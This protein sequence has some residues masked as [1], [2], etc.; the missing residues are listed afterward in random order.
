MTMPNTS[1]REGKRVLVVDDEPRMIGFIRMNLELEGHLVI[2]AHNGLEALDAVRTQLPDLVLLDLMMPEIDGLEVCRRLKA[3]PVTQRTIYAEAGG[4]PGHR[5]A[6]T[7]PTVNASS[8]SFFA[9]TLAALDAAYLRP[10][11]DGVL[12]FQE[13]GGDLIH[14]WLREGGDVGA[15]LDDLDERYRASLPEADRSEV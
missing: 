15:V 14:A 9:D 4:Q 11:Y 13:A 8:S 3:D 12:G 5:S 2:E 10:R 7:D 6:W 1:P